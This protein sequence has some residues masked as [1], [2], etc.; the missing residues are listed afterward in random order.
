MVE[1]TNTRSPY[2]WQDQYL[3]ED[4]DT[5]TECLGIRGERVLDIVLTPRGVRMTTA[6]GGENGTTLSKNQLDRFIIELKALSERLEEPKPSDEGSARS[7]NT[8]LVAP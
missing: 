5:I 3:D 1:F 4:F 8:P 2:P 6:S 7:P